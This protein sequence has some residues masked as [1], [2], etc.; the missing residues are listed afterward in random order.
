[1]SSH[2]FPGAGPAPTIPSR[3][4]SGCVGS[5]R[6]V[7]RLGLTLLA[8]LPAAVMGC[9]DDQPTAPDSASQSALPPSLAVASNSWTEKA[10]MPVPG[11]IYGVSAGVA[12][13]P[14]GQ[15]ILYTFGGTTQGDGASGFPV[16]A[17]NPATDTW[18]AK[19][20]QV[21]AFNT[22]GVGRV[23][24]RLYFSGGEDF[25]GGTKA[26]LSAVYAYDP[27]NDRLTRQADMP[28]FTAEGVTGVISG[29]LY[30][31]PGVCSGD[32]WPAPGYCETEPIRLFYR[33]NPTTNTWSTRRPAPHYHRQGA[34]GV[35]SGKFYVA[36]GFNGFQAVAALD[37]YDPATNSWTTGAPLPLA[38]RARGTVLGG[39]LYVLASGTGTALHTYVYNPGTNTWTTR[40]SP[41]FGHD[42]VAKVT[43]G[44]RSYLVAVSGGGTDPLATVHTEEYT[45]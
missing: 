38:G 22:N 19:A 13:N 9:A 31:L 15:S 30:V 26:I 39:K 11:D 7:G 2:D 21:H 10:P 33:F 5:G 42:D 43:V 3:T 20:S 1:M 44:T 35:I 41:R 14:A 16:L 8:V 4:A 32:G 23:G 24:S 25:G 37:I 6:L 12:P 18:T 29:K 36:G 45:P 34:A 27:V 28:K 40:A 17:Y